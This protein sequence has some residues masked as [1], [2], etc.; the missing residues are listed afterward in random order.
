MKVVYYLSY[1][2]ILFFKVYFIMYVNPLQFI[3]LVLQFSFFLNAYPVS[4]ILGPWQC[5]STAC[6]TNP[7]QGLESIHTEYKFSFWDSSCV[8]CNCETCNMCRNPVLEMRYKENSCAYF[9]NELLSSNCDIPAVPLVFSPNNLYEVFFFG[10]LSQLCGLGQRCT[11]YCQWKDYSCKNKYKFKALNNLAQ[12][13][14]KDC[15]QI[16]GAFC[17]KGTHP[18]RCVQSYVSPRCETCVFPVLNDSV[19]FRYGHG[20][21][22]E[23]CQTK[24]ESAAGDTTQYYSPSFWE[25]CAWFFTPKW[26]TGFC[27]IECNRG[28]TWMSSSSTNPMHHPT[29]VPCKTV[30]SEGHISPLCLGGKGQVVVEDNMGECIPCNSRGIFLPANARWVGVLG[31]SCDWECQK[32]FYWSHEHHQCVRCPY[33]E[34]D[35]M[36][37]TSQEQHGEDTY[38]MRCTNSSKGQCVT[39]FYNCVNEWLDLDITAQECTCRPCSMPVLGKTYISVPC[40]SGPKKTGDTVLSNCTSHDACVDGYVYRNC[41]ETHDML[42][43]PCTPPVPGKLLLR[44]CS[45]FSDAMYGP[46]PENYACNGSNVMRTCPQERVP[47]DGFCQCLSGK[48][49]AGVDLITDPN[50]N[51]AQ[52]VLKQC[53]PTFYMDK[54]TETCLSCRPP[55]TD[56]THEILAVSDPNVLGI[57]ACYCPSN[58]FPRVEP[59]AT[60]VKCWPCGDLVCPASQFQKQT[61]CGEKNNAEPQ[62]EC[63]RLPGVNYSRNNDIYYLSCEQSISQC[64]EG[65]QSYLANDESRYSVQ[66]LQTLMSTTNIYSDKYTFMYQEKQATD[67]LQL[68]SAFDNWF[69]DRTIFEVIPISE[70]YFFIH[71]ESNTTSF[72]TMVHF[73][74]DLSQPRLFDLNLQ[75]FVEV[76]PLFR[77]SDIRIQKMVLHNREDSKIPSNFLFFPKIWIVFSYHGFCG[78]NP[79]FEGPASKCSS[80]ELIMFSSFFSQNCN[81]PVLEYCLTFLKEY[82][83]GRI[84]AQWGYTDLIHTVSLGNLEE[85]DFSMYCLI[86]SPLLGKNI[87]AR[88]L[89]YFHVGDHISYEDPIT[90]LQILSP[91]LSTSP[92]F[93]SVMDIMVGIRSILGVVAVNEEDKFRFSSKRNFLVSWSFDFYE[94]SLEPYAFSLQAPRLWNT[95]EPLQMDQKMLEN[96]PSFIAKFGFYTLQRVNYHLA[97]LHGPLTDASYILDLWNFFASNFVEFRNMRSAPAFYYYS[98]FVANS[99]ISQETNSLKTDYQTF[100]LEKNSGDQWFLYK[101]SNLISCKP[102]YAYFDAW[103]ANKRC[104]PLPCK[105]QISCG[106]NSFRDVQSNNCQ[107]NPGYYIYYRPF[108]FTYAGNNEFSYCKK[109]L[110]G[111]YC[112]GNFQPMQVCPANS[113]TST[114]PEALSISI[115]D[116]LCDPGYYLFENLCVPCIQNTFCPFP[117]TLIPTT[118]H[119]GGETVQYKKSDPLDCICPPRTHGFLCT[120]CTDE[121]ICRTSDLAENQKTLMQMNI[122]YYG[123]FHS[124]ENLQSCLKTFQ[125]EPHLYV[126][127][128]ESSVYLQSLRMKTNDKKNYPWNWILVYESKDNSIMQGIAKC[129]SDLDFFSSRKYSDIQ[130]IEYDFNVAGNVNGFRTSAIRIRQTCDEIYMQPGLWEWNG[131]ASDNEEDCVCKGG[132]ESLNSAF[133]GNSLNYK[134]FPCLNGTHRPPKHPSLLC[135]QS[136][137]Y[138]EREHA[139]YIGM[140]Y[141]ICRPGYILN[142]YTKKCETKEEIDSF[143]PTNS[144]DFAP[145]APQWFEFI[146]DFNNFIIFFLALFSATLI[147]FLVLYYNIA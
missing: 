120:P 36:Y 109:C 17:S 86:S 69:L 32:Y 147:V 4:D 138:P 91:F 108:S 143:L 21:L 38:Y 3:F 97:Y 140:S 131:L 85:R 9:S 54:L 110:S 128:I 16:P 46:C 27:E 95:N 37:D 20:M 71:S 106:P 129:V 2:Y 60:F 112:P 68:Q 82:W 99:Y 75:L 66:F 98:N 1:L 78:V 80:M 127:S 67:I 111:N 51:Y 12:Y 76:A 141:C 13:E 50:Y 52:C 57:D 18:V 139:P 101:L 73:H 130:L 30:C 132:Y 11:S 84:F 26:H 88:Y 93:F 145:K 33:Q 105:Y 146:K 45:L 14:C 41:S 113:R 31:K 29:C 94:S 117:G 34:T 116:C 55:W 100:A 79:N 24:Y 39:C 44:S 48:E 6:W 70:D 28:F 8:P 123:Y 56:T 134:C 7:Y 47:K 83:G 96:I 144:Q 81:N 103:S 124:L 19:M 43:L 35:C 121:E 92:I 10:P 77:I 23:D 42:C 64:S 135:L 87:I 122:H 125:V 118:C 115:R 119:L 104:V 15:L 25:N 107:C 102:D 89:L 65:Y 133:I 58:Y 62:C 114:D 40:G 61:A 59:D 63:V 74:K 142:Q 5:P 72:L 126:L 136:C 137:P 22:F 49:F 53:P 90:V